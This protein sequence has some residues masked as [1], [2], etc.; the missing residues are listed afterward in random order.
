MARERRKDS[1]V[2]IGSAKTEVVREETQ[3]A[4]CSAQLS[5]SLRQFTRAGDEKKHKAMFHHGKAKKNV[6]QPFFAV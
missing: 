3:S 4:G 6:R 1:A 2:E 5:F